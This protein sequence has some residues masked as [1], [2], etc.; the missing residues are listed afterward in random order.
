M[1]DEY[2]ASCVR[3]D[4]INA[5]DGK[6]PEKLVKASSALVEA[7][8]ASGIRV[9]SSACVSPGHKRMMHALLGR[10]EHAPFAPRGAGHVSGRCRHFLMKV[11]APSLRVK[12]S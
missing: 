3:G 2:N 4:P 6:L 10:S 1:Y 8:C 11:S 5:M 9:L 7:L 12:A